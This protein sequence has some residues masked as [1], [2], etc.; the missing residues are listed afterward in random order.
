MAESSKNYWFQNE[1]H[2]RMCLKNKEDVINKL[3]QL[4]Y[5]FDMLASQDSWTSQKTLTL[6]PSVNLTSGKD[7]WISLCTMLVR[8]SLMYERVITDAY[9]Q[10]NLIHSAVTGQLTFL[11]SIKDILSFW[12]F[13][14]IPYA[15]HVFEKGDNYPYRA[16]VR[17]EIMTIPYNCWGLNRP[18][19]KL[20]THPA[21]D[22]VQ[23]DQK[24][25][26][27]PPPFLCWPPLPAASA[28]ASTSANIFFTNPAKNDFHS[29]K[30]NIKIQWA[31]DAVHCIDSK[32]E[33]RVRLIPTF[34][35]VNGTTDASLVEPGDINS[36]NNLSFFKN[37]IFSYKTKALTYMRKYHSLIPPLVNIPETWTCEA[38]ELHQRLQYAQ[39]ILVDRAV[40]L[41]YQAQAARLKRYFDTVC[42]GTCESIETAWSVLERYENF[43]RQN[44][45]HR[46]IISQT[47]GQNHVDT[48]CQQ[49]HQNGRIYDRCVTVDDWSSYI[50]TATIRHCPIFGYTKYFSNH[51]PSPKIHFYV[52]ISIC[53][54][55]EP[56]VPYNEEEE[57]LQH[58]EPVWKFFEENGTLEDFKK[59]VFLHKLPIVEA[60]A[61]C[62]LRNLFLT[63]CN[64]DIHYI[65]KECFDLHPST[66]ESTRESPGQH[67]FVNFI[68]WL[69]SYLQLQVLCT[70]KD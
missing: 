14:K 67:L 56:L 17:V 30:L 16:E 5:I 2:L 54:T 8:R 11:Q 13:Q 33:L 58:H 46:N 22:T 35:K 69:E 1:N 20:M 50:T 36:Q 47:S 3:F 68:H 44:L 62:F 55:Y 32:R 45:L 40:H 9:N 26:I 59:I 23:N 64:R 38:K 49:T 41:I 43:P 25:E 31:G 29:K 34:S 7:Q 65:P 21:N 70:E 60:L 15:R 52:D 42:Y 37:K 57:C 63:A 48:S 53:V 6:L 66:L 61:T 24:Y 39:W 27:V 51:T 19:L 4:R 12:P 10:M 28:F 18:V